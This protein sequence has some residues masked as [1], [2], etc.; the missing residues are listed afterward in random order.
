MPPA[1]VDQVASCLAALAAIIAVGNLV[2]W[3]SSTQVLISMRP[4][5][6]PM[7]PI[8]ALL[9]LMTSFGVWHAHRSETVT[10]RLVL[11]PAA[12]GLAAIL[13]AICYLTGNAPAPLVLATSGA[14]NWYMLP[15]W[16][17][18]GLLFCMAC[19]SVMLT[20]KQLVTAAQGL[21]LAVFFV[22]L[23][24]LAGY[25]LQDTFLFRVLP[26]KGT[27]ILT[28]TAVLLLAAAILFSRPHAGLM[29]AVTSELPGARVSRRLLFA[30]F[31]VPIMAAAVVL[32]GAHAVLYDGWTM[33]IVFVWIVI[34]LFLSIVWRMASLLAISDRERAGAEQAL[35]Q[36][37]RELEQEHHSKDLFMATLAHELRNPLAP[38]SSAAE[39]LRHGGAKTDPERKRLGAMIAAQSANLVNLV[40]DLMDIDRLNTGRLTLNKQP[41]DARQVIGTAVEQIVPLRKASTLR[42]R[43]TDR[44]SLGLC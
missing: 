22:A 40:N 1:I 21:S 24:N 13:I 30:A 8:T 38:I 41:I 11:A 16:I 37:V 29:S 23:L 9:V 42:S 25:P 14:R 32:L 15:S 17:T 3:A 20:K 36:A 4:N 28:S 39:L 27:S 43:F 35:Q 26:N 18:S 7:V 31:L 44:A 33:L 19:A 10:W 12:V 2:G 6:P 5:L 34:L